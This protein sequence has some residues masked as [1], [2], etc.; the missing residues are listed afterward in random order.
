MIDQLA[1]F[2]NFI[3]WPLTLLPPVLS[4]FIMACI[5]VVLI[6]LINRI[7]INKNF[8][9]EVREKMNVL[10]EELLELQ[11]KGEMERAKKV[12][13]EI[14]KQNL[15]Y[16]KHNLKAILVSIVV[17]SLIIPWVQYTYKDV[18]VAKLPFV[19]PHINSNLNWFLW[20]LIAS[21]AVSWV[22]T[23]LVGVEYG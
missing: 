23:R 6:T 2:L 21:F 11:K 8:V 4:V 1:K 10:R 17:I 14:T 19:L 20:Y 13:D 3:F 12:L 16:L 15:A 9:K 5:V 22:I 18:T 7:F